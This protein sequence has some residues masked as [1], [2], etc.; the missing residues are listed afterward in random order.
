MYVVKLKNN[1][2]KTIQQ[3]NLHFFYD[4]VHRDIS[5]IE[6]FNNLINTSSGA[7][8]TGSFSNLSMQATRGF[9]LDMPPNGLLPGNE[10]IVNITVHGTSMLK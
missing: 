3:A 9:P 6:N 7:Y 2:Y 10:M 8:S 4:N 1:G 5:R